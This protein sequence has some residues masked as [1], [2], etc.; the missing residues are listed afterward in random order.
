VCAAAQD[1]D[2][3]LL[4][5]PQEMTPEQRTAAALRFEEKSILLSTNDAIRRRLAPIRGIPTK[6]GRMQD[7]NSDI[8]EIFETIDGLGTA[9]QR[10][11]NSFSRWASGK[12][13]PDFKR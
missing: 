5:Q 4:Q 8:A 10:L 9:P 2:L 1:E 13:D 6:S 3:K 11:W 12:D 7:P